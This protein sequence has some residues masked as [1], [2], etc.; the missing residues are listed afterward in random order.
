MA[1]FAYIAEY[2]QLTQL[3]G[4]AGQMPD[5]NSKLAEQKTGDISGG[6]Q[7]TAA[8]NPGTKYVRIHTDGVCSVLFGFGT[9]GTPP[10][11]AAAATNQRFAA[12]QTEF[13][14][15]PTNG[16]GSGNNQV[17]VKIDF[18]TNT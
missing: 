15:V 6:H 3:A 14:G 2:A 8:L 10:A 1:V 18:I 17:Q 4:D 11:P 5:E 12:N 16:N 9:V 7:I 13:K